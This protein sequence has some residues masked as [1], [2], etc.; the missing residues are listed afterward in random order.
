VVHFDAALDLLSTLPDTPERAARELDLQTKLGPV[1]VALKGS[2]SPEAG[3]AYLRARELC[4]RIGETAR[5]FPVLWGIWLVHSTQGDLEMA[6]GLANELLALA[7]RL[8]D[9]ALLLQAHH[10]LWQTLIFRGEISS[11]LEHAERGITLYQPELH[12]SHALLYGGHDPG[13]CCLATGGIG[14]WLLG[15][16]Q[17]AVQ[18]SREALVLAQE[19]RHAH[20]IVMALNIAGSL[21]M[22]RR[23]VDDV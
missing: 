2:G 20:S 15:Y 4:Q 10:A 21:H 22:L 23:R 11:G 14:S 17:Q 13:V 7:G 8:Q 5:L 18:K 19:L 16:V 12:R 1:V 6:R 3:D 9:P